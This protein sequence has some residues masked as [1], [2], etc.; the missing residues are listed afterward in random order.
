MIVMVMEVASNGD[1]GPLH[2]EVLRSERLQ[3]FGA[4][5]C[6][7]IP[8]SRRS[9][10]HGAA[11]DVKTQPLVDL[12]QWRKSRVRGDVFGVERTTEFIIIMIR[13]LVIFYWRL[14]P[15]R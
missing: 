1:E 8:A 3:P 7:V 6:T 4:K 14:P 13:V 5:G 9:S 15:P 10:I 2:P 11:S 12:T